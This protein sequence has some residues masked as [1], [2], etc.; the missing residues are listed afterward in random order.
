MG[1]K[2]NNCWD[3]FVVGGRRKG[4]KNGKRSRNKDE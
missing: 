4:S 3:I 2:G 1:K